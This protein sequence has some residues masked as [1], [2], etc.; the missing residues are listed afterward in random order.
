MILSAE[1]DRRIQLI[2]QIKQLFV[3]CLSPPPTTGG[4]RHKIKNHLYLFT[5]GSPAPATAYAINICRLNQ[6]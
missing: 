4:Y 1:A 3:Y 2:I 5:A 6:F